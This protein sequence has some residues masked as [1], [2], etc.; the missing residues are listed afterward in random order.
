MRGILFAATLAA[1]AFARAADGPLAVEGVQWV[2][3]ASMVEGRG[4]ADAPPYG[5][6]PLRAREI[7]ALARVIPAGD[8][9][10]GLLVRFRT[11][12]A[13]LHFRYSLKETAKDD[14]WCGPNGLYGVDVYAR[15][16]QDAPWRFQQVKQ[17]TNARDREKT[18]VL[19]SEADH[20]RDFIVYLPFRGVVERFEIGVGEGCRLERI[21]PP[22][23]RVVHYGT[24]LVHGG[25][26]TRA[27]MIFTAI[28]GR[29]ADIE[30]VNLGFSGAAH[31]QPEM[32]DLQAEVPASLHVVDAALN[33]KPDAIR[34][35]LG[36]YVKRLREKCPGTPILVCEPASAFARETDRGRAVRE[37][38]DALCAEGIPGL[39]YM[40]TAE[41]MADDSEGT[42]DGTH[43]NEYGSMQMGRAFAAAVSRILR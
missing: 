42:V 39:W 28:Y 41:Q 38:Y 12:S 26:V 19:H 17:L 14:R 21:P 35:K 10:T 37:V 20:S 34:E 7:G 15:D 6:L 9:A 18:W 5:R 3:A 23:R 40:T 36:G 16:G 29:L 25:C 32:A 13:T 11:D 22:P 4:F 8:H 2:D 24:S 43:P 33:N 31:L 30:V 1:A 27:G